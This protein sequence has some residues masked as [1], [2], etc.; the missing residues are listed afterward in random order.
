[1]ATAVFLL[2]FGFVLYVLFGYPLLLAVW[3]ARKPGRKIPPAAPRTV[4]V[5]LP[6]RNGGKWLAG[7]L[8]SIRSLDYPQ[9]LVQV[10]VVSDGSTDETESIA[11]ECPGVEVISLPPSGKA[12]ALNHGIVRATGEILF[13]T[14]VRQ[15]LEPDSLRL[16]LDT[17]DDPEVGATSGELIIRSGETLGEEN[18]GLY[19]RYEKW[20]RRRLSEV[21]S[22]LGATGAIYAMRRELAEPLPPNT[23]LDDV[24]LPLLG[25]LRGYRI[26]FVAGALAYDS[27]TALEA[28]FRRKVRTQ[29]GIYQLI[30]ALP[31]LLGPANRMWIHF[32]SYK[33]GRL[34]LPF[35]LLAMLVSG[36]FLP[37][38]WNVLLTASQL[39][40]YGAAALDPIVPERS[41]LKR[42]T[43]V[44]RTFVV[45]MAAAASAASILF[46]PSAT[47]WAKPTKSSA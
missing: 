20:I 33:L 1:M 30:G 36:L 47:F 37:A 32:V 16:L 34:L 8:R 41:P 27:P 42:L 13:L 24:H 31:A 10:I 28:E 38:P 40:F 11:G 14:D 5:I 43:S 29:A 26:L 25:F 7:K 15:D 21:D 18:V 6:V 45:L 46:R 2:S 39:A 4:S 17:F 3:P 19:W 35:A 9:E 23:L 12:V 22:T 44:T